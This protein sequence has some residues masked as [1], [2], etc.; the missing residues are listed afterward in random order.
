MTIDIEYQ[1]ADRDDDFS[2]MLLYRSTRFDYGGDAGQKRNL[3]HK[4]AN[5]I[6]RLGM[7]IGVG[8]V[9]CVT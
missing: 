8:H 3:D 6:E 4:R 5:E 7:G 9:R 2:I 1:W